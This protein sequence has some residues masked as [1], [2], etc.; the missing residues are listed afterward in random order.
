MRK[1][2]D[3]K[4]ILVFCP[5]SEDPRPLALLMIL[6]PLWN[7]PYEKMTISLPPNT[8]LFFF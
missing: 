1:K 5:V 3:R 8:S 6:S 2:K 7:G 4:Y